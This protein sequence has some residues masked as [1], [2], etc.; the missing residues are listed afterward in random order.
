[1]TGTWHL[2]SSD[3]EGKSSPCKGITIRDPKAHFTKVATDSDIEAYLLEQ[4]DWIAGDYPEYHKAILEDFKD[5]LIPSMQD[6]CN[7]YEYVTVLVSGDL[8]TELAKR[9]SPKPFVEAMCMYTANAMWDIFRF[10]YLWD[11]YLPEGFP[12]VA[13]SGMML[14]NVEI[15]KHVTLDTGMN[16]TAC[17][18]IDKKERRANRSRSNE[19]VIS[20]LSV[21]MNMG[22]GF[23]QYRR[24][25][26]D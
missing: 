22:C 13:N 17:W 20:F 8:G 6:L 21:V 16:R 2:S 9:L 25:E 7:R 3:V 19:R 4:A 18:T 15:Y 10:H 5:M 23:G 11:V 12:N 26:D 1:M 24:S 14:D